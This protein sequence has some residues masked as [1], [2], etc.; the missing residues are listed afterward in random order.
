MKYKKWAK[1]WLEN[2]IKPTLK[3]KT[4]WNY[5]SI[6]NNYVIKKFG[7]EELIDI[8]PLKVQVY[9]N[10]LLGGKNKLSISSVNLIITV[11]QSSI[12]MAFLSNNLKSYNLGN[13]RRPHLEE[14]E[15]TCFSFEE[16]KM[17]ENKVWASKKKKML[18]VII[19]LYTGMRIGE[20][21]ALTWNDVDIEKRIIS[22]NKTC[23]EGKNKNGIYQRIL[24]SPKTFSSKRMIPYPKQLEIIFKLLKQDNSIYVISYNQ[25][26]ISVRSYQKS[27]ALMLKH[28]NIKHKGFHALRHTFATRSIECG[29]DVKTLS[30]IL[31]H[32]NATITLNRYVHSLSNHKKD[33]MDKIGNLFNDNQEKFIS[34]SNDILDEQ[35]VTQVY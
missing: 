32:K 17:I 2:Y 13:I 24:N 5:V 10:E 1:I 27:F 33:M 21:L 19:C 22:I 6:C 11:I 20:L 23:H 15:I 7:E 31:G 12:K 9:I 16:Q 26:P 29:V 18:G 35:V 25:K 4:Y 3:N 30:E 28:A 34:S 8:T 14:K